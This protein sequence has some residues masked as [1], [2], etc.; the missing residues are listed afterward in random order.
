V[1]PWL[2]QRAPWAIHDDLMIKGVYDPASPDDESDS[3]RNPIDVCRE[4]IGGMWEP[5]PVAWE[6]RKNA[7]IT[8][9]NRHSRPGEPSLSIDPV[10]GKPLVQALSGRWHYPA[11]RLGGV[12]K[13]QPMKPNHPWE[14]LGDSFCYFICGALPEIGKGARPPL[15]TMSGF[16]P[17]QI[18]RQ[19]IT[20][21][22]SFDPRLNPRRV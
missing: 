18:Q 19:P 2:R 11:N 12:S 14:D 1:L 21:N 10:D 17:R 4:F 22:N 13:D 20:T 8:S 16:D 15:S 9:L 3:D 5:G 7:L 6:S